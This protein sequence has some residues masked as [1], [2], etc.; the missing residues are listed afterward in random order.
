MLHCVFGFDK[1]RNEDINGINKKNGKGTRSIGN[2][3]LMTE[4][5]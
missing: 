1:E 5:K 2:Q 4:R 3:V